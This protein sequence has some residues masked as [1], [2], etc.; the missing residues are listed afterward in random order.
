MICI[1]IFQI[2]QFPAAQHFSGK[3]PE[4]ILEYKIGLVVCKAVAPEC[5]LDFPACFQSTYCLSVNI[6]KLCQIRADAADSGFHEAF[7]EHDTNL[8]AERRDG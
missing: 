4:G 2:K 1:V 6:I 3:F 7:S 8:I 5:F